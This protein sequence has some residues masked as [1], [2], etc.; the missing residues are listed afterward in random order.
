MEQNVLHRLRARIREHIIGQALLVDRLLIALLADGHL[1]VEG[2]PGLAKTRAIRVMADALEGSFQRIQFTPD[3][4]PADLTGTEIYRPQEG[5]FVFRH[6]PLFHNL[7]LADEINRAP[8]KVQSALLEAMAERQITV[9]GTTHSLPQLF[10]VMATQNPIEQEGTY[11]LP[12]A[13][14]D[15]FLMYVRIDYPAADDERRILRLVRDEVRKKNCNPGAGHFTRT[16]FRRT[17]SGAQY[18]HGRGSRAVL[19]AVGDGN[20][21]SRRLWRRLRTMAAVR[22][23]SARDVGT[24]SLCSC[25]CLVARQRL[26]IARRRAGGVRRCFAPPLDSRLC[27]R[28]RRHHLRRGDRNADRTGC[29]SLTRMAHASGATDRIAAVRTSRER[30][31]GLAHSARSLSLRRH[32]VRASKTDVYSSPFKGRG[33]EYDE[34]RPYYPGD[35]VRHMDWRVWARTGAAYTKLFCEERERPVCFYVDYRAQ[36][37]FATRRC[38]KSVQATDI[39]ALLAWSAVHEGDRVGGVLF[40][41]VAHAEIKPQRGKQ[42]ILRF[43]HQLAAFSDNRRAVPFAAGSDGSAP[44]QRLTHTVRPGSLLFLI[45]D[46]R[47]MQTAEGR[48]RELAA[49]SEVVLIQVYDVLEAKVPAPGEYNISDGIRTMCINTADTDFASTYA[50]RFRHRV[51]RLQSF[52]RKSRVGFIQCCTAEE[53]VAVLR[54]IFGVR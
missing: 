51:M 47:D 29:R 32:R 19:A 45:S 3:L 11:P 24:G 25:P 5:S 30:L 7:V 40:S 2:A 22:G 37:F 31:I 14:L 34:S 33:M 42:G 48:I 18:T 17:A 52:A 21:Q 6:G 13:Q 36:M 39:A 38:F 28:G 44:L 50:D 4:L 53:P 26:C 23:Q 9:G 41:E 49:H 8:A 35:D 43:I 46:F 10:L 1:L 20:A 16:D 12:E 15:R 27:C 54:R